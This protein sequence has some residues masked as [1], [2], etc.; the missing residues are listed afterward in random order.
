MKLREF[1]SI[2]VNAHVHTH[3]PAAGHYLISNLQIRRQLWAAMTQVGECSGGKCRGPGAA[4][5]EWLVVC[6]S[7]LE[8]GRQSSKAPLPSLYPFVVCVLVYARACELALANAISCRWVW[9][10]NWR[11]IDVCSRS[12]RERS[13]QILI[14]L[15]L[16]RAQSKANAHISVWDPAESRRYL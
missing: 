7:R 16:S 3:T 9:R 4:W 6:D 14:P 15:P 10:A 8:H 11:L 5:F 12:Q 1:N 13:M 2:T